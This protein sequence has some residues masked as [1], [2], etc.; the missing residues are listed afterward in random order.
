LR[1]L[2]ATLPELAKSDAEIADA[3]NKG[4]RLLMSVQTSSGGLSYWPGGREPMLWGSAYGCLGLALAKRQGFAVA[5]ADFT[6]LLVYLSEQL[7]GIAKDATGYGLSDR[8]L[9]IYA[10]AVAGKAEP[11]YHDL[12]FQ[13][14]AKLSAEDRALVALAIIEAKGPT[15]MIEELLRGPSIDANYIEQWFGSITRENALHL[16]A[17]T[18]FQPKT[19]RVDQLAL[20]L[21][22]RRSNGH[23]RTTQGNA[24]SILALGSYLRTVETGPRESS[25]TVVWG[26]VTEPFVLNQATRSASNTFQIERATAP[27]PITLSKT[28]GQ[29][30]S[31]VTVAARAKLVEQSAQDQGYRLTRRYAKLADDGR[32]GPAENLRVGDRV[33][34]T[35]DVEAR[36]R[37]TFIALVDPL[38]G[39]LAPIN[40]AFKSQEVLAGESLGREWVS[41]YSELHE[42]R[43]L[44]FIDVLYPGRYTL[45]YLARCVSAGEVLAPSAKVEEMYHPEHFGTTEAVRVHAQ[46]LE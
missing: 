21:F 46:P 38:P 6:R 15:Q 16:L 33:L 9:A 26:N 39:V 31:E 30:F 25:G 7:R 42:D 19:A 18:M 20:D 4:N 17:W 44:F 14:R 37:G 40:P 5:D 2:R 35:L 11:A 28:G 1:D 32:L 23:W 29:V 8:C 22:A 27:L 13:K 41:D 12:L 36:R 24:W 34:I 45:R 10:L 43:A 3:V